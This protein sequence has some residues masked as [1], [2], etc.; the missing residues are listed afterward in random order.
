MTYAVDTSDAVLY[1]WSSILRTH[2]YLIIRIV[3]WSM[4][5]LRYFNPDSNGPSLWCY[6][7]QL[8]QRC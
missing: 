7:E 8:F 6:H 1:L 2:G 4:D 3:Y 5:S